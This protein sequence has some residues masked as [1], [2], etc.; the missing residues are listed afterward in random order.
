MVKGC[1][2]N[3][4]QFTLMTQH[5]PEYRNKKLKLNVTKFRNKESIH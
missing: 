4:V 3:L 1:A 5:L 2:L